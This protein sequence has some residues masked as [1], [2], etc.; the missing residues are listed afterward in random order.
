MHVAIKMESSRALLALVLL[1]GSASLPVASAAQTDEP[2]AESQSEVLASEARSERGPLLRRPG[3]PQ[4]ESIDPT[5]GSFGDAEPIQKP[6]APDQEPGAEPGAFPTNCAEETRLLPADV[7]AALGRALAAVPDER[8]AVAVVDRMGR[9]L[10]LYGRSQATDAS[11]E[12][13]TGLA[14]TAAIFSNNQAP[15][16]S[17]T[18]RFISGIHFP[19]GIR[20]TPNAALY[21]IE[22]TN[23]G[24][25]LRTNF[26]SG[27]EV[28]Q[29]RRALMDAPCNAQD[30]T[31][32]GSGPV[33][34]KV[35]AFDSDFLAVDPGGVPLFKVLGRFNFRAVG[36]IG[37]AGVSPE[38]AEYAA[39]QGFGGAIPELPAPGR[40][41]VDGIRLPFVD[42]IDPPAGSGGG[43]AARLSDFRIGPRGGGCAPEGYLSGPRAGSQL[44][45]AEVRQIVQDSIDAADRTRA[46]IRL[47]LG[48]RARMVISVA[49]LDGQILALYR[50]PDATV[51][52]VDV[53]AAKA[54][55]VVY[56]SGPG[57][58]DL[59]GVPQGT[60]ISNRSIS[61]GAQ[62]L[63]PP[64]IDGSG[65]GPFF[66]TYIADRQNPC[67]QG[68]Q[69]T[70][71]FQSGI[72]F[73]PGSSP[74]Y[75]G[76]QLVGGLGISGDGVEQDDY[77]TALGAGAFLPPEEIRSDQVTIDGVRLPFFK[78]PRNPEG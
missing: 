29:L 5:R 49:D 12:R 71:P 31:G 53:A 30:A 44:S 21:G 1:G 37:V 57:A 73:F 46:V 63:F 9:I 18:V 61:F 58:A 39:F 22:N 32:C 38:L 70:N 35:D 7:E 23:R 14:R 59:R 28:P 50:M 40:V 54:R 36:G 11:L 78:F 74:L 65:P 52:S 16:S 19:P 68:A 64:G 26:R 62:P 2:R 17:R 67:S 15:L 77:V 25:D 24:C 8:L 47:P 51:F 42:Q 55:N 4:R 45:E 76:G 13:A 27:K 20:N 69:A 66:D 43:A 6:D 10:A 72:V 56:F 3:L 75:R 41:F 60:A 48:S 33:T 34:G